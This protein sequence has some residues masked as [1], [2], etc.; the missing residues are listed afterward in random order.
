[1]PCSGQQSQDLLTD[2]SD[3]C[4]WIW[5]IG[6]SVRL[7]QAAISDD[8]FSVVVHR[9]DFLRRNG[10]PAEVLSGNR[11]DVT[12]KCNHRLASKSSR[13]SDQVFCC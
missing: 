13:L 7:K 10:K 5:L 3:S 6:D 1:M 8:I 9:Q 4:A 2:Q 11:Y 12:A